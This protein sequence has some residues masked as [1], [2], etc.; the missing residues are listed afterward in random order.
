ME[1]KTFF[2]TGVSSGLGKAIA[3]E[4]LNQGHRVVGT[5]RKDGDRS[6]FENLSTG[7]ARAELLD[8]RNFDEVLRTVARVEHEIAPIDV[9]INNAG[10]GVEGTL[11]ESS[12]EILREQFEVNV[13]GAVAVLKAVLPNMRKRRSGRI[14]NITSMAGTITMPGI[15]YYSGS[16]FALEGISESLA[17]EVRDFGIFVTAVAPG[18]FRTDW[19]GR[20]MTRVARAISDY[21]SVFDPIRVRRME[22]SGNQIGDPNKAAKAIL[23]VVESEKPPEHLLLGSDAL[24]LVRNKLL[25]VQSEIQT[26]EKITLSTDFQ[27]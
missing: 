10:Y 23:Q 2:I 6:V 9:L 11:E 25:S 16:K 8:V 3:I 22:Y 17:K 20:S 24:K 4:A 7:N 15:S 27:Q 19:A 26:W 14:I 21:D 5:V 13:F 18:S 1:K 12:M